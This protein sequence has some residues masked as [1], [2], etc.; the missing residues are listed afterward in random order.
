MADTVTRDVQQ[1]QRP[2]GEFTEVVRRW[3]R[4][5]QEKVGTNT[6]FGENSGFSGTAKE[7]SKKIWI[8]LKK[9]RDSA[10][11]DNI[12]Q[13]IVDKSRGVTKQEISAKKVKTYHQRQNNN[14]YLIGVPPSLEKEVYS[15]D[16]WPIGVAF[17]RFNFRI[18]QKFLDNPRQNEGTDVQDF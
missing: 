3:K 8:F 17:D 7:K 11:E 12:I 14:H 4:R 10:N 5:K 2:Q 16:F 9:V 13:W 6:D 15:L 1:Q 18:G